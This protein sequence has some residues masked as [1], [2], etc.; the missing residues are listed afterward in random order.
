[1]HVLV[2]GAGLAGLSA[3]RELARAGAAVTVFDARDRAGGRV[4]TVQL[5]RGEHG[6]LGGEFID[7]D[8]RAIRRLA[9]EL[10]LELGRVLPGGFTH[11]FRGEDGRYHVSRTRPW[12][13][14]GQILAPL[15]DRY[16][17][18]HGDTRAA[19]VRE[20]S[21]I[22][23]RDWL[24]QRDASRE[25][26][27]MADALRGFFLADPDDLSV[28]PV[29][30]QIAEGGSPAQAEMYRIKGGNDRLVSA[31]VRS[32]DGRVLL[33]HRLRKISHATDRVI[34]HVEDGDGHAQA[35]EGD[36]M[37]IALPTTA[38][39][40]VD[41][42]PALPDDQRHAIAALR[43]GC[44]TKVVI[45]ST[46]DLFEGR[47]ARAF[48]TDSDLGAFWDGADGRGSVL[49]LLG[50]GCIS[51]RLR[52]RADVSP[53]HIVGD[54]C[55]LG[56]S[57]AEVSG[58][59]MATWEEDPFARGGYAYLDPSFDPAWRPLLARRTGQLVFAGEHTSKDWQ[60][61]MN[62]AVESGLTAAHELLEKPP[63]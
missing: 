36:A 53:H 29:V 50:G 19:A 28:L 21:T 24:R 56:M 12:T 54:L 3:A 2:A 43:Y 58:I 13:E 22:S 33:R 17:A 55:W 61:Y 44:A 52:A 45:Q 27:S 1:M 30:E 63:Q 62:G 41:V 35:L 15:L 46:R 38:L 59:R 60:G 37:V 11:R 16:K 32:I 31:L 9:S 4:W 48:A 51:A 10:G 6:E 5:E 23:L 7:S 18:A 57:G 8:H 40:E 49:T 39:V 25:L 34:A 26:H 14:L 20:I 42:R 47:K